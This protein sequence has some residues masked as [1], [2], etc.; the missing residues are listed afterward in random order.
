MPAA[1][2]PHDF[3]NLNSLSLRDV[4]PIPWARSPIMDEIPGCNVKADGA[5]DPNNL[6]PVSQWLEKPPGP[7]LPG[8]FI[9]KDCEDTV[10]QSLPIRESFPQ[11]Q[12]NM[13]YPDEMVDEVNTCWTSWWLYG[14]RAYYGNYTHLGPEIDCRSS[15]LCRNEDG[16]RVQNCV[17]ITSQ[18]SVG[19]EIV[20]KA[21]LFGTG[22][23]TKNSLQM[24]FST[25]N[26]HCT[27]STEN[28]TWYAP[29]KDVVYG[30]M[31]R[32]CNASLP[33]KQLF[34]PKS[35][36]SPRKPGSGET[37]S[38][39]RNS[40]PAYPNLTTSN[41]VPNPTTDSTPTNIQPSV[42]LSDK[43]YLVGAVDFQF[44]IPLE[45]GQVSCDGECGA[46]AYPEPP[47]AGQGEMHKFF[48]GDPNA[49][50]LPP[51]LLGA[52]PN[53]NTNQP[54]EAT[55]P[56]DPKPEDEVFDKDSPKSKGLVAAEAQ[57]T[58]SPAAPQQSDPGS[59]VVLA[60]GGGGM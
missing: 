32:Q 36:R 11:L 1:N 37:T 54:P 25:A 31:A 13:G 26:Q 41:D 18:V 45:D 38:N 57:A 22:I 7:D 24:A 34:P 16:Q 47:P 14:H 3:H 29:K 19:M 6:A 23:E 8:K 5:Q 30:Y 56:D 55:V 52:D 40:N 59:S 39:S 10:R 21:T 51:E 58:Q 50:K 49:N 27:L 9:G 60:P 48:P 20:I 43:S 2:Q 33:R 17:T 4:K 15:S 42:Q 12:A 53:A 28:R 35:R 44:E 46:G